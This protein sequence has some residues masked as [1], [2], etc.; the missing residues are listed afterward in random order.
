[1]TKENFDDPESIR[2][3]EECEEKFASLKNKHI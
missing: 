1:M 2:Y 3:I